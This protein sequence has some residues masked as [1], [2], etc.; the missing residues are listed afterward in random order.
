MN[1]VDSLFYGNKARFINHSKLYKN[2]EPKNLEVEGVINLGL[3]SNS[4]IQCGQ[5]LLFDYDGDDVLVK[6]EKYS[7]IKNDTR[8][9]MWDDDMSVK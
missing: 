7:W 3:F 1:I 6:L 2:L 9:K 4:D 8:I 5:E